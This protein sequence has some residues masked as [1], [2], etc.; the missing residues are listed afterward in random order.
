M[1]DSLTEKRIAAMDLSDRP[2][3]FQLVALRHTVAIDEGHCTA[4]CMRLN[5]LFFLSWGR[6]N[7]PCYKWTC[8]LTKLEALI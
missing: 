4:H 8:I 5:V 3:D 2:Y 6:L 1:G 7:A